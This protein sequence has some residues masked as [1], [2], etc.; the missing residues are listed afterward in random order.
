VAGAFHPHV[1]GWMVH[2]NVFASDEPRVIWGELGDVHDSVAAPV[3]PAPVA[4]PT[5]APAVKPVAKPTP[6]PV[7]VPSAPA[8][9]LHAGIVLVHAGDSLGEQMQSAA[10]ALGKS[11]YAT[12]VVNVS[13]AAMQ[14]PAS[15]RAVRDAITHLASEPGVDT[16]RLAL[17]GVAFGG[18]LAVFHAAADTRVKCVVDY[19]GGVGEQGLRR[20]TRMP[21]VDIIGFEGDAGVVTLHDGLTRLNVPTEFHVYPGLA[22]KLAPSDRREAAQGVG[23]FLATCLAGR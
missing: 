23:K 8:T 13:D 14:F 17:L 7:S 18:R 20:M 4:P 19:F 15:N 2:A 3:A 21:P 5:P 10:E 9:V 22:G 11:G 1:Y 6:A 16:A 12:E